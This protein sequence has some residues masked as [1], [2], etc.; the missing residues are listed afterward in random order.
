MADSV[1]LAPIAAFFPDLRDVQGW[2]RANAQF[3]G[4]VSNPQ[5][6]GSIVVQ[7]G[8]ALVAPLERRYTDIH[9]EVVFNNRSAE[10]RSMHAFS[11]GPADITGRVD[12][13]E[14]G[15][16]L[17]GRFCLE[18]TG[19]SDVRHE[20]NVNKERVAGAFFVAHLANGFEKR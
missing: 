6:T 16:R 5:L 8:A 14:L 15:N 7:N 18:F 20:R 13:P 4:T 9:G 10:I 2:L 11:G 3:T 19:S 1:A 12:F 17:L